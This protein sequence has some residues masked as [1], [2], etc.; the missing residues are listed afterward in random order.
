MKAVRSVSH[1][2]GIM[3]QQSGPNGW[4]TCMVAPAPKPGQMT[5]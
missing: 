5:L 2:F 4:T 3:E 1:A